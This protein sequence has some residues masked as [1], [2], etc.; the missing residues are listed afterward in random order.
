MI[1]I[2]LSSYSALDKG[3]KRKYNEDSLLVYEPKDKKIYSKKG[4]L[5]IVADGVGGLNKGDVASKTA[6]ETIKKEYYLSK[7]TNA[8]KALVN[9]V[10]KANAKIYS[11]STKE[12]KMGTTVVCMI[13]KEDK[14]YIASVG[15]SRAYIFRE[16]K[17]KKLTEDHSF[18]GE[19]IRMGELTEEQARVHPRKNIIL[20][21]LG[22]KKSVDIDIFTYGIA[23]GDKFLLCSD[24]L[25][26]ELPHTEL[27]DIIKKDSS[28]VV[29]TLV[30]S[31]NKAGGSDNISAILVDIKELEV[32]SDKKK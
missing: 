3:K 8:A 28:S 25:W 18:V 15:D 9:A 2:S 12:E 11:L 19:R 6:V 24:G 27:E 21:C 1:K 23:K 17:L 22:D 7:S 10:K 5:Y 4:Y 30:S 29:N 13:I 14:A 20:R 31:A 32:V 26:G 16:G